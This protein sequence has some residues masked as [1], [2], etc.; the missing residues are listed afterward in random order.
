MKITFDYE[1]GCIR[2]MHVFQG[3][4]YETTL[5]MKRAV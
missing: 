2:N 4:D 3:V 1:E 5:I